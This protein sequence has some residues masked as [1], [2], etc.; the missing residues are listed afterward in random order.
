MS[1]EGW[2]HPIHN[3]ESFKKHVHFSG[4]RLCIQFPAMELISPEWQLQRV[5]SDLTERQETSNVQQEQLTN[6]SIIEECQRMAAWLFQLFVQRAPNA[7]NRQMLPLV[8]FE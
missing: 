2:Q 3:L 8:L 1:D 5:V 6:R 4:V 7:P